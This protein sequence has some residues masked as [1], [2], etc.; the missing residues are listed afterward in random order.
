MVTFWLV[1]WNLLLPHAL[2][3][4]TGINTLSCNRGRISRD[5]HNLLRGHDINA[6]WSLVRSPRIVDFIQ[7]LRV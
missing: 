4:H 6:S 1:S 3:N 7:W 5:S 2:T